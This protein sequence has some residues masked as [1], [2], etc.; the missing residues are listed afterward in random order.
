MP[1]KHAAVGHK[2]LSNF[3]LKNHRS[4]LNQ[5]ITSTGQVSH[6]PIKSY[7][8]MKRVEPIPN[9]RGQARLQ[10]LRETKGW[11]LSQLNLVRALLKREM[12][13]EKDRW[14]F[15]RAE[16]SDPLFSPWVRYGHM[17]KF[18]ISEN[19]FGSPNC[20]V[21]AIMTYCNRLFVCRLGDVSWT[22]LSLV[23]DSI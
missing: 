14:V 5:I 1:S 13:I 9:L 19:P 17:T 12:V 11:L 18:V 7:L 15:A 23:L 2:L 3:N 8:L 16:V 4:K 10:N 6:S 22:P 20:M 21:A